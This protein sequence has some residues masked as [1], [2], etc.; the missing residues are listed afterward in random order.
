[1]YLAAA[2]MPIYNTSFDLGV[3]YDG[4]SI[5]NMDMKILEEQVTNDYFNLWKEIP[6]ESLALEKRRVC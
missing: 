2:I 4:S 5:F 1:M 3:D 6:T